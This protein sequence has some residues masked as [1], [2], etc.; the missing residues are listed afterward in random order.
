MQ[1]EKLILVAVIQKDVRVLYIEGYLNFCVFLMY[2]KAGGVHRHQVRPSDARAYRAD[3][4]MLQQVQD[5]LA[6]WMCE[7]F[8]PDV[9]LTLA[10]EDMSSEY[11]G[12]ISATFS[13]ALLS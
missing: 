2:T 11:K 10:I 4:K 3:L 7:K 12:R 1:K 8:A 6:K 5:L 13:M 9:C